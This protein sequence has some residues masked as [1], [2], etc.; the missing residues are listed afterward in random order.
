MKLRL[1]L[2]YEAEVTDI[3]GM[4]DAVLNGD[5]QCYEH[6]FGVGW[7]CPVSVDL[8]KASGETI[9]EWE[10]DSWRRR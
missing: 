8:E 7:E 6:A 9:C 3:E 2:I 10:I 1:I 5:E 4:K